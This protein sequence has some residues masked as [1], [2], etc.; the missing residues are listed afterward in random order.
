M[1]RPARPLGLSENVKVSAAVF[2]RLRYIEGFDVSRIVRGVG[3]TSSQA[4]L[5][6]ELKRFL[7]LSL[8]YPHPTYAFSPSLPIDDVWH[9]FIL[10]TRRYRSFC[11]E[12]YGRYFDHVPGESR[13]GSRR[14]IRGGA[15]PY[16][17]SKLEQAFG[18]YDNA[19]WTGDAAC[20]P[21]EAA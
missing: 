17:L 18:S 20:G 14:R 15:M 2:R 21:C 3:K 11:D 8:I 10:S 5:V 9:R 16:T 12:V 13:A 4:R 19:L 7:A 6:L 1:P